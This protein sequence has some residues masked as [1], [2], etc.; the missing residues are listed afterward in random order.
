[1][2]PSGSNRA[3]HIGRL[4]TARGL[5]GRARRIR[6]EH[7][8]PGH[9]GEP[10]RRRVQAA[11][12]PGDEIA[13]Q[14]PEITEFDRRPPGRYPGVRLHEL[15]CLVACP[16]LLL[17]FSPQP[18][19]WRRRWQA[20]NP[21]SSARHRHGVP[22]PVVWCVGIVAHPEIHAAHSVHQHGHALQPRVA[23]RPGQQDRREGNQQHDDQSKHGARVERQW[24]SPRDLPARAETATTRSW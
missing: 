11:L 18:T 6:D 3:G 8:A 12:D 7:Q 16:A 15:Q 1:M 17:T 21:A 19:I 9:D 10:S 22:N 23:Q 14:T 5:P 2:T 24:W 4:G 20:D 13:F